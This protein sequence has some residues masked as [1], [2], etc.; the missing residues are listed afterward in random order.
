MG[1]KG[2]CRSPN[3]GGWVSFVA[4][5]LYTNRPILTPGTPASSGTLKGQK[6]I[7]SGQK[8][9]KVNFYLFGF[10]LPR[11]FRRQESAKC[12]DIFEIAGR[13]A[14]VE[15]VGCLPSSC[16]LGAGVRLFGVVPSFRGVFP[17]FCP[18]FCF[19]LGALLANMALFRV[20]R[21]F[22]G[23][24]GVV[25]WVCVACVLCVACGLLCA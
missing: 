2:S 10:V 15:V 8:G 24:F 3:G 11:D 13:R 12:K 22:L 25:V 9:A 20:F 17:P 18:L 7:E 14:G 16:P 5:S 19:A 1:V 21:A 6:G 4:Y 23:G